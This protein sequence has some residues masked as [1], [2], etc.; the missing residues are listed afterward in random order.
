MRVL[1]DDEQ[2]SWTYEE[3]L[4][5][6]D[7][8]KDINERLLVDEKKVIVEVKVDELQDGTDMDLTPE[9]VT[10]DQIHQISFKT[11][12]VQDNLAKELDGAIKILDGVKEEI[13]DI[14]GHMLSEEIEQGMTKLS[15]NIGKM[16]WLFNLFEQIDVIGA[17]KMDEVH[18]GDKG[19]LRDFLNKFNDTLKELMEAMENNDITLIND[20]LEYELEPAIG[21]L[22][23]TI[24]EIRTMVSEFSFSED[25]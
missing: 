4:T 15:D 18:Y 8:I 13:N 1:V 12:S 17:L 20:F 21:E 6:S 23:E 11:E 9:Q 7:M 24:P 25:S 3:D 14:V 16:I 19:T 2:K 10:L 22:E 5:L